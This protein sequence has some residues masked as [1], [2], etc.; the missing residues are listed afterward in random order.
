[1]TIP[2]LI[3]DDSNMARKQVTK[4]LP[5]GWDVDITYAANG[6]EGIDAIRT[7][8]GEMVFLDLTMPEMDGYQ[9]LELVKQEALKCVVIVISGDVQPAARERVLQ[10]GALDFIRKP[11]NKEKLFG[12]LEMYGLL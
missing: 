1:M 8:K 5:D 6:V 7:G 2:L 4:S 9:V 3:C 11:I 10:L 12:V